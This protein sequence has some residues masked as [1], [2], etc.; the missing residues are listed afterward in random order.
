MG[1]SKIETHNQNL[2]WIVPKENNEGNLIF[3]FNL[4]WFEFLPISY[5]LLVFTHLW[6]VKFLWQITSCLHQCCLLESHQKDVLLIERVHENLHLGRKGWK[7]K[8][9]GEMVYGHF[10]TRVWRT[11]Y[12]R[13]SST[14]KWFVG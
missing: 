10:A 14:R 1:F 6:L 2:G 4:G 7:G 11:R 9:Q 3:F 5:V 8:V 12:S 13:P